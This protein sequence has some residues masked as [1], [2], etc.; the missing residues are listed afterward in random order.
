MLRTKNLSSYMETEILMSDFNDFGFSTVSADEYEA[1]QTK[2]VD[3]ACLLYTSP[4]PR[5]RG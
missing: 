5:D 4:S 3:T 1:Q 2:T